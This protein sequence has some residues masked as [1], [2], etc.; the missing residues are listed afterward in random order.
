[1][2][3]TFNYPANKNNVKNAHQ[4]HSFIVDSPE[5]AYFMIDKNA[6]DLKRIFD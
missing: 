6:K 4:V 2:I 5:K 3:I 1:M